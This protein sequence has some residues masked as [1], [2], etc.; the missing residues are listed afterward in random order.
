MS[1]TVGDDLE[2]DGQHQACD[3]SEVEE[4]DGLGDLE[5]EIDQEVEVN[6][7]EATSF[8]MSDTD[9]DELAEMK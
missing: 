4:D 9:N 1:V 2:C 5:N 8:S 6:K 3:D 7:K